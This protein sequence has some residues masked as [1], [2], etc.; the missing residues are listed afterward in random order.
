MNEVGR[1]F[2]KEPLGDFCL[3]EKFKSEED[4]VWAENLLSKVQGP[5]TR[6]I[7]AVEYQER[8]DSTPRQQGVGRPQLERREFA[9]YNLNNSFNEVLEDEDDIPFEKNI[10][11][12]VGLEMTVLDPIE[13]DND[14][15]DEDVEIEMPQVSPIEVAIE[16]TLVDPIEMANDDLDEVEREEVEV[17]T[18]TLVSPFGFRWTKVQSSNHTQLK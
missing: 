2:L 9:R 18:K 13:M 12:E 4:H 1:A 15:L 11:D 17:D 7:Q 16:M 3:L 14:D 5:T 8:P 6:Q 10:D